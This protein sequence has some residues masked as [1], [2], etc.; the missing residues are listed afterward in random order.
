MEVR[1]ENER[2]QI[3]VEVITVKSRHH[4]VVDIISSPI[5]AA[6]AANVMKCP[7][8]IEFTFVELLVYADYFY[9]VHLQVML[10]LT[11]CPLPPKGS[12][13]CLRG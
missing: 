11:V 2:N 6:T 13:H 5:G 10:K 3:K 8:S 1:I 7:A 9:I 4:V 12:M